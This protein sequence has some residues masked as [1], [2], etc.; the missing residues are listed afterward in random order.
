MINKHLEKK[1]TS[2]AIK[3]IDRA[4]AQ[5]S[6]YPVGSSSPYGNFDS[7]YHLLLW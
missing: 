1:L 2:Y 7:N 4:Q 6:G 3:M 5:Y